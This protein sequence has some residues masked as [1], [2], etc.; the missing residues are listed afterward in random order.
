MEKGDS[1]EEGQFMEPFPTLS[2][3]DS[4]L[5]KFREQ[6]SSLGAYQ[7]NRLSP[8]FNFTPTGNDT[9]VS[10]KAIVCVVA[11]RCEVRTASPV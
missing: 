3:A 11:G 2:T 1:R 7:A 5:S 9:L 8:V 10:P 4:S 6:L